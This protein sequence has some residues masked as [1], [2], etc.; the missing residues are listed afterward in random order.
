MDSAGGQSVHYLLQPV[1]CGDMS[2]THTVRE[3]LAGF[4][5]EVEDKAHILWTN[6]ITRSGRLIKLCEEKVG[7]DRVVPLW[8]AIL[9]GVYLAYN[10]EQDFLPQFEQNIDSLEELYKKL[11]N[12]FL[13]TDS[14]EQESK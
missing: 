11:D 6:F 8:N 9:V 5:F 2:E 1:A 4:D 3:W 13:M 14:I 10:I 7:F 12:L